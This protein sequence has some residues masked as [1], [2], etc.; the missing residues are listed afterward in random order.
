VSSLYRCKTRVAYKPFN[1]QKLIV[2]EERQVSDINIKLNWKSNLGSQNVEDATGSYP[3]LNN[4]TCQITINDPYLSGIAWPAVYDMAALY[5]GSNV[6]AANN[7]LLRSCQEGENPVTHKCYRYEDIDSSSAYSTGDKGSNAVPLIADYAHIIISLWY[8][9]GGINF[10]T[11]FYF[12]LS[13]FSVSHGNDFPIVTLAGKNPAAIVFNQTPVNRSIP[14][15]TTVEEALKTIFEESNYGVSFCNKGDK[16]PFV[17]PRAQRWKGLTDYELAIKQLNATGGN[18]LALPFKEYANKVSICTRADINQGC[19]V[20]YLG[21]GL[22]EAYKIDGEPELSLL[23]RNAEL[24][25]SAND[26][27]TY[28]S[29]FFESK[30]Y[31]V[32]DIVPQKRKKATQNLQRKPFPL[33]FT[34][35][36]KRATGQSLSGIYWS[37]YTKVRKYGKVDT[38][39][40]KEINL[41]GIFENSEAISF[42]DGVVKQADEETGTVVIL[43][44][45]FIKACDSDKG[46]H[47]CFSRPLYQET[48]NL[49]TIEVRA[50][51]SV[52]MSQKIG[53][54]TE[55]RPEFTRFYIAP[56]EGQITMSPDIVYDFATPQNE[57]ED[58]KKDSPAQEEQEGSDVP[59][60]EPVARIGNTGRSTGPH[61][62]AEWSDKRFISPDDVFKYVRFE[63][64][65]SFTSGYRTAA[66][67][68]HNGVDLAAPEGTAMYLQGGASGGEVLAS[69]CVNGDAGCGGG[70]GNFITINTPEGE[71]ILAHLMPESI[72]PNISNIQTT[73]AG[74]RRANVTSA[75]AIRG[76]NIETEF[77]GVPRALRMIPGRTFLSFVTNYDEWIKNNKSSSIDPGVWIPE[78][79]RSWYLEKVTY[80]WERGDLRIKLGGVSGWGAQALDVPKFSEYLT[81]INEA[82][83][84]GMSD[85]YDYI[86][87]PGDLCYF[88]K[89][90]NNL[91]ETRCAEAQ[92]FIRSSRQGRSPEGTTGAGVGSVTGFPTAGCEYT[93]SQYPQDRVQKIINAA[94]SLGIKTNIGLA[95]VVG[96][97]IQESTTQLDP[98]IPGDNGAAIG[99]FQWNGPRNQALQN[100]ARGKGADYKNIDVQ[101]S[102]FVKEASESYPGLASAVNNA[103]TLGD[104]TNQFERI[105]ERAGDPRLEN[106]IAFAN[107]ILSGM[108]CSK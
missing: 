70:F 1:S 12:R 10:G 94:Y 83:G 22:Y 17:I 47:K 99:I 76:I 29:K 30:T 81:T 52:A 57:L 68:G 66:R 40:D 91:C 62:H 45:Y 73:G 41:Y 61:L 25:T 86:R 33:Q 43:T 103:T 18:M 2:F 15:G 59:P 46:E 6:A 53:S 105:Y 5:F 28:T 21:K 98:T 19:S 104:A 69:D 67:P 54:S 100:Y 36:E 108:K 106:R 72:S 38:K 74:K 95:A 7:V 49:E 65:P 48:R 80:E 88:D 102:W 107:D 84:I 101:M 32:D 93:S 13:S 27:S 24:P 35:S 50:K 75:P 64:Q 92:E 14:E 11:D 97:A 37:G 9:V 39:E 77:K 20:F 78:D 63:T 51:Q 90:G 60:G 55:E 56:T 23:A 85:Y 96:N 31:Y 79:F 8:D 3:E 42:Y 4:S 89:E 44:N 71:M 58:K 26:E 87:S 82:K 16:E 34:K